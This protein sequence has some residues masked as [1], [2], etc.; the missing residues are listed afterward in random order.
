MAKLKDLKEFDFENSSVVLWT[1]KVGGTAVEKPRYSAR[2]VDTDDGVKTTLKHIVTAQIDQIEETL[3]YSLTAQNNEA[4]VLTLPTELT[5]AGILMEA[6]QEEAENRKVKK[7]S[8]IKNSVFYAIKFVHGERTLFAVRKTGTGWRT[9]RSSDFRQVFYKDE[10]L[11][12]DERT[13]FEIER[14]VDLFILNETV[15]LRNKMR[16]ESVLKYKQAHL[17]DFRDLQAE[18]EFSAIFSDLTALIAYIGENKMQLRRAAAIRQKGHYKDDGFITRLRSEY[19]S[20]KLN[21]KF[22]D[23]GKIIATEENAADIMTALLDH[24]L[25]SV[26]SQSVYDVQDTQPV[27]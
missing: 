20:Q 15:F 4:S 19:S 8:E 13:P 26:F 27:G 9:K 16:S 1:Y 17:E 2:W 10:K 12:L 3:E 5:H 21:I 23:E 7:V 24:R 22:D 11:T 25:S 14:S 6:A 18:S